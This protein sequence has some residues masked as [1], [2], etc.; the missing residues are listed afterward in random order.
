MTSPP[1]MNQIIWKH[2]I[3]EN[4]ECINRPRIQDIEIQKQTIK[5]VNKRQQT[6]RQVKEK[7]KDIP[8]ENQVTRKELITQQENN[9]KSRRKTNARTRKRKH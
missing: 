1:D 8:R 3:A 9:A 7:K 2:I 6:K 4:K 5:V